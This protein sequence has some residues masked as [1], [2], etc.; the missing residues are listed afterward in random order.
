[1]TQHNDFCLIYYVSVCSN[2]NGQIADMADLDTEL[3]LQV[4]TEVSVLVRCPR[5]DRNLLDPLVSKITHLSC[6]FFLGPAWIIIS[7]TNPAHSG[8]VGG[9]QCQ[10]S[11][12]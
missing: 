5:P 8:N 10:T 9:R 6:L 11:A 4:F 7:M 12:D 3:P 2:R 1:M